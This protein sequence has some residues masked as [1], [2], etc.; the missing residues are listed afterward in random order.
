MIKM[1]LAQDIKEGISKNNRIPWKIKDEMA[2]FKNT[3]LNHIVVMGYNTY[4]TLN[5]ALAHRTNYVLTKKTYLSLKD[6]IIINNIDPILE[7]AKTQDVY[8]I[9]GKQI[10][11]LF[12][13]Y[14]DEIIMSVINDD[15]H[16][17]LTMD[18]KDK[19][20]DFKIIDEKRFNQFKVLYY[21]KD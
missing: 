2:F 20:K 4:L 3:T 17:D 14:C 15:Y 1:I 13:K 18:W 19:L 12:L 6:A 16:C 7:L 10:Y 9:G 11:Y 5:K 21:K 8:I